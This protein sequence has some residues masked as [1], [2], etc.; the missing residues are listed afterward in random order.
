MAGTWFYRHSVF[1]EVTAM[2]RCRSILLTLFLTAA[3]FGSV[4]V[5][6]AETYQVGPERAHKSLN[7]VQDLLGPGDIVEVDG[8]ATYPGDVWFE[9]DGQAGSPVII[10]GVPI[11]GRLPVLSGG[12]EWT[13]LFQG[14]HYLF[15]GFEVTGGPAY[16]VVHKADDIT[17]RNAIVH[18]CPNHGIMGTDDDSGSLTI[19]HSE[20]FR[21]G[22]GSDKHQLY[23][24]TDE[25]VH[26]GSVFRLQFS[27]V[28]DG[29]GGNNVKTR[30]ERNEIYFNWIEG[31][32]YHGLDMIGP[33]GGDPSLAR[34]DS[35]VVG[36]VI[37]T[38][39]EWQVARFGGDGSGAT[40]GRYRFANNTFVMGPEGN[41][42][43]RMQDAVESVEL[44]NN[45]FF[46]SAGGEVEVI[47][48][49]DP[50]GPDPVI[51][52]S[53]NWLQDGWIE[54]PAGCSATVTGSSPGFADLSGF[55]L[56]PGSGASLI[57]AGVSPSASN[58]GNA[59][60]NPFLGPMFVP[61]YRAWLPA[62][63]EVVR[64]ASGAIDIGAYEEGSPD[65]SSGGSGGLGG[66]GGGSSA[67]SGGSSAGSGGTTDGPTTGG[68]AGQGAG[69]ESQATGDYWS[70]DSE[71]CA[72]RT[73]GHR[74][75][76]AAAGLIGVLMLFGLA[77]MRRRRGR[78]EQRPA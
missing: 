32:A 48:H 67:G 20:V 29:N 17:I 14:N 25:S 24:A 44:Y 4:H 75:S 31:A 22:S 37:V 11:N 53:N 41:V 35:D 30:A 62:G 59:L 68:S 47:R 39:S 8:D 27:Y 70:D 54:M 12:D 21:C 19:E 9:N 60:P 10:R 18:D 38:T 73:R 56:R 64:P 45:V 63:G 61:P 52:G 34:E 3:T 1:P 51:R 71:G 2:H 43:L 46:Q 76:N 78:A 74:S 49:S 15:D 36:N 23:I 72:C 13:V 58:D 7:D 69:A 26:P 33:D 57:D 5:A 66:A 50:A 55:D 28:H 6:H 16:C 77:G 42:A 65:V 40:A